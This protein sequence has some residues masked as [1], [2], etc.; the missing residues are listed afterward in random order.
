MGGRLLRC[1][2]S[3]VVAGNGASELIGALLAELD[4]AGCVGHVL[5]TYSDGVEVSHSSVVGEPMTN[6]DLRCR[7]C[8]VL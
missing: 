7:A 3:L 2:P 6:K 8:R 5:V 4:G 1:D